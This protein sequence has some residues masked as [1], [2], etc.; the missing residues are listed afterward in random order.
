MSDSSQ[1]GCYDLIFVFSDFLPEKSGLK[2]TRA[3]THLLQVSSYLC[4]VLCLFGPMS[5]TEVVSFLLGSSAI[6]ANIGNLMEATGHSSAISSTRKRLR[7]SAIASLRS[8]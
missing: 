1:N 3:Q 8:Y 7:F 2:R 6:L 5:G 4:A